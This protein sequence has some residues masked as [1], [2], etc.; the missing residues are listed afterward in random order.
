MKVDD[1]M[2][3]SGNSDYFNPLFRYT[4]EAHVPYLVG[5]PSTRSISVDPHDTIVYNQD[6]YGYLLA[7]G[8]LQCYHWITMRVNG[9][10]SPTEF[11]SSATLILIPNSNEL[12]SLR[13]SWYASTVIKT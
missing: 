7:V 2:V 11:D 5:L 1:Y 9:Y 12:E 3:N 6:L 8:V 10:F 13:Q 4:L